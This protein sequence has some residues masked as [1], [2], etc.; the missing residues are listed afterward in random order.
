MYFLVS[1]GTFNPSFGKLLYILIDFTVRVFTDSL[2]FPF[3][4]CCLLLLVSSCT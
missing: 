4:N 2:Y 1:I 3:L